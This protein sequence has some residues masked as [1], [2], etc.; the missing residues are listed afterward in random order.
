MSWLTQVSRLV[1]AAG[2]VFGIEALGDGDTRQV[3]IE[4]IPRNQPGEYK[5]SA[6]LLWEAT[7]P[8]DAERDA[9]GTRS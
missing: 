3:S 4:G 9:G 1:S 7:L 2:S 6:M 8:C 5:A